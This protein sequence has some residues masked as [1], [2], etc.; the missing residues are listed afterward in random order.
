MIPRIHPSAPVNVFNSK[1]QLRSVITPH[2]FMN[3]KPTLGTVDTSSL[4]LDPRAEN[5]TIHSFGIKH[6]DAGNYTCVLR[7]ATHKREHRIELH[8]QGEYQPQLLID[9]P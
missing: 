2:R 7:N 1:Y 6:S 5:Q 9:G 8:V 4:V 3:G